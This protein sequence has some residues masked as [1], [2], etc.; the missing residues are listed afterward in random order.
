MATVQIDLEV[1]ANE[2]AAVY[3]EPGEIITYTGVRVVYDAA[4][5][6]DEIMASLEKVKI[7]ILSRGY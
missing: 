4:L 5:S 6:L 3:T 1:A 7:K 2:S